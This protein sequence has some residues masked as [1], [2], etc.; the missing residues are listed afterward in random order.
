MA[1]GPDGA[2]W[3]ADTR[4]NRLQ[5]LDPQT[6]V[7]TPFG[8][9]VRPTA[10]AVLTSGLIAVTELGADAVLDPEGAAGK[11][12]L[13]VIDAA[14][15]RIATYDGLDRPEGVAS[16]GRGGVLV[17]ETQRD[18]LLGFQLAGG[19]LVLAGAIASEGRFTRP[20]GM[21]VDAAGRLLVADAYG[22]RVLR[23]EAPAVSEPGHGRRQRARDAR[24]RRSAAAAAS[25]RS[26]PGIERRYTTTL[27]AN[28]V[29]TAG[30]RRAHRHRSE[31]G[32]ARP[33][34]QRRER[35]RAPAPGSRARR[36][37]PWSR[38]GP[39]RP[40]RSV[41]VTFTQTIGAT[42]PLRTGTYAK[43]LTFTLSTTQP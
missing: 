21:E 11:G 32:G 38:P 6:G 3:V 7:W 20:I 13:I 15:T 12:R 35:A 8:G 9:F 36:F 29:S 17:A 25:A 5:R 40:P 28:V 14:G 24:A 4:N 23:F 33:A 37:R 22:N 30:E 39:R 34:R 1:V 2:V 10:V 18:R 41:S 42:E 43:A 27:T 19:Q 16:D 26:R 31:P